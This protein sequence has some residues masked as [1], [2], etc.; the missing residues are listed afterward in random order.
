M[1]FNSLYTVVENLPIIVL[2]DFL[3]T[4]QP[5]QPLDPKLSDSRHDAALKELCYLHP[6]LR[7]MLRTDPVCL[8]MEK[9][10]QTVNLKTGE[11]TSV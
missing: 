8:I 2:M 5:A 4:Y 10:R 7:L 6:I 3:E 1:S 9:T 11:R